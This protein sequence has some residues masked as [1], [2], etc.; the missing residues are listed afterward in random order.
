MSGT[1]RAAAP[2][3]GGF[4]RLAAA[5]GALGAVLLLALIVRLA[6]CFVIGPAL[7]KGRAAD[8]GWIMVNGRIGTDP[9]DQIA[10]NLVAG[11]GYVDDTGRRNYERAPGYVL[12]LAGSYRLW[13]SEPWKV[14]L[15][16]SVLDT[17]SCLLVFLLAMRVLGDRAVA[18]LAAL[19]Y[20]VYYKMVNMVSRPMSET[21][22]VFLIL[23]FLLL[24][25]E[26]FPKARFAFAAGA[27][28]GL[29][30]LTRPV[31]LLFP[32]VAVVL[33]LLRGRRDGLRRA[34]PFALAFA[35]TCV[36][37]PLQNYRE[38]GRVFFGLGGGKIMYMGTA[39]DY[40]KPFR[41]EE[42]RLVDEIQRDAP[43]FPYE[44]RVDAA[45]GSEALRRIAAAPW[46]YAGRVAYRLYLF[47]VYPDFSTPLMAVKSSAGLLLSLAVCALAAFGVV[48]A[49]A[50]GAAVAP[51]LSLVLYC[52]A[53]YALIY[54]TPRYAMPFVP[55]LFILA[56]AGAL[57]AWRRR[58]RAAGGAPRARP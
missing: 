9:Y 26:S 32:A 23:V 29:A 2:P 44:P 51:L 38:T 43:T 10:R 39:I 56:S 22:Y 34:V 15:L 16:Q 3:A 42:Q 1:G 13:G 50:A 55:V 14:Q 48:A 17:A 19:L 58:P 31:T 4:G 53:L 41:G 11:K 12:F 28:L 35:L 49:R 47:W 45:F 36:Y 25:V 7:V 21:L 5:H 57:A 33:Y 30:T 54:A 37:V 24:F 18:L 8:L 20:A 6:Y 40:S 52:Y 46:A 27:G